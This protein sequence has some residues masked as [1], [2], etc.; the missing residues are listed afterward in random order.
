MLIASLILGSEDTTPSSC[1][2][3]GGREGRGGGGGEERGGSAWNKDKG[4]EMERRKERSKK[5][6][7][8]EKRVK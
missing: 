7:E 5:E 3:Q 4:V 8:R 1:G 2:L 6:R